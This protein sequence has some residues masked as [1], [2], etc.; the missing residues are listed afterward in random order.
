M[1]SYSELSNIPN[2]KTSRMICVRLI[3]PFRLFWRKSHTQRIAKTICR[4]SNTSS[5]SANILIS[6]NLHLNVNFGNCLLFTTKKTEEGIVS[7][8]SVLLPESLFCKK[9]DL[10]WWHIKNYAL[11]R[12]T[13]CNGSFYLRDLFQGFYGICSFGGGIYHSLPIQ[14]TVKY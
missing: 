11:S 1:T 4:K 13:S 3:V 12:A 2:E 10:L 9:A 7:T 5:F 6:Y 8:L 14:S